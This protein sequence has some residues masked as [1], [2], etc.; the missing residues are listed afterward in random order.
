[1]MA[2]RR[3]TSW[4]KV[5]GVQ[6][7]VNGKAKITALEVVSQASEIV[8]NCLVG[9]VVAVHPPVSDDIEPGVLLVPGDGRD[10]VL[11]GLAHQGIGWFLV[12]GKVPRKLGVPPP[13]IRIV[14][15]HAGRDKYFLITNFHRCLLLSNLGQLA[16]GH[17]SGRDL[18]GLVFVYLCC[19]SL[20]RLTGPFSELRSQGFDTAKPSDQPVRQLD[21][22]VEAQGF[23]D[24]HSRKRF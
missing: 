19:S 7:A 12:A 8:I 5:A 9:I 11:Q 3:L 24:G 1:M 14:S 4:S 23:E 15:H 20:I 18:Q 22:W 17:P 16:Y 13:W 10:R 2:P 21:A 6:A